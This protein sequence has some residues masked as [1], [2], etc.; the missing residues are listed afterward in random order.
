[1]L[2][3]LVKS[4]SKTHPDGAGAKKMEASSI[5]LLEKAAK[6][7]ERGLYRATSNQAVYTIYLQTITAH[8]LRR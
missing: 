4:G 3:V 2:K 5:F 8:I 7:W 1:M 6:I